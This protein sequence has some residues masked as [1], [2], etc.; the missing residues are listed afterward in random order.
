MCFSL[1][2]HGQWASGQE[3]PVKP[4]VS[5]DSV[6]RAKS[7]NS[8]IVIKTTSRLAG[9]I[10]SLTW[11]GK[12]F[13]DSHDH[14]RQLQSASNFDVGSKFVAET[15]NPTE[16]GSRFDAIGAATTSKLLELK[17]KDN[18][19]VTKSQMAFWLKPGEKSNNTLAKNTTT[20]SNHLLTKRVEIGVLGSENLISYDVTFTVPAGEK[21]HYAQFE[22]VTGYMPA[23]FSSF[24]TYDA[25][26]QQFQKLSIGPGEQR[27]PV[28]LST[29]NGSHAMGIYSP[30]LPAPN[31]EH[32]GYGRFSFKYAKVV[33]WNS[34]YR[35]RDHQSGIEPGEYTFRNYVTVGSLEDVRKAMILLH[36]H[37]SEQ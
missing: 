36:Q 3:T 27:K 19:L 10:D 20:L 4:Q 31:F 8:E 5:G 22:M 15:F 17:A 32:A 35:I 12:Q 25:K 33:K 28:V 16:A 34:V 11:N 23:E 18:V 37:F 26:T 13:I 29:E 6:I 7:G 9:A 1:V 2:T 30:D 24:Y 14:G 21:H